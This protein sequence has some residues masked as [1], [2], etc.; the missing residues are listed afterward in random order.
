MKV[1]VISNT[2]YN[3]SAKF[4]K[5]CNDH[6]D[7][8]LFCDDLISLS[9]KNISDSLIVVDY[10]DS[11]DDLDKIKAVSKK[12]LNS[13]F[14]IIMN[15]INSTIQ[16]KLTHQGFDLI[17]SKQSFLINFSTIKKQFLLQK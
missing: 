15:V 12:N 5:I 14:C 2:D 7:D 16:R 17:M 13:T 4:S 11:I 6:S 1:V 9:K 10:D 3:F 8:L